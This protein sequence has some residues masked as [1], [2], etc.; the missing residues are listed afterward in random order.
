MYAGTRLPVESTVGRNT[1]QPSMLATRF[2][3]PPHTALKA[4]CKRGRERTYQAN[5]ELPIPAVQTMPVCITG[6]S[7]QL[8]G[9]CS[10][11]LRSGKLRLAQAQN[12][13]AAL[14][15]SSGEAMPESTA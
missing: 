11:S 9:F 4:E 2:F 14:V 8:S 7:V 6:K 1:P 13:P 10:D 3:S 5:A 15:H 12:R